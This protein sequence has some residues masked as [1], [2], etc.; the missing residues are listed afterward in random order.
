VAA[1]LALGSL[2]LG[3]IWI[4]AAP[5]E[6]S[7]SGRHRRA[8]VLSCPGTTA[9]RPGRLLQR[10]TD[11]DVYSISDP[12]RTTA[13]SSIFF[14][15]LPAEVFD[16]LMSDSEILTVPSGGLIFER[17]DRARSVFAVLSGMV[18]LSIETRDGTEA[19]VEVFHAGKSFAEA[20][21]FRRDV[22]PVSAIAL[23]HSRILSVPNEAV[24]RAIRAHPEAAGSILAATYSHLHSLVRQIEQ[25]KSNTGMERVGHFILSNVPPGNGSS[26]I[27]V[28]YEKQVLASLLGMKPETL[29]RAFR[30]LSAYGVSVDGKAI[31]LRDRRALERF[32][33]LDD[34]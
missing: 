28:P 33:E 27:Q 24:Q 31:I 25:L 13:R 6:S 21:A 3:H 9:R 26:S 30:K 14:G 10:R 20:L 18:K 19:I 4:C 7:N 1:I 2:K 32:L 11:V 15:S 8:L 17:G 23:T 34:P 22:Y 12:E 29:S 5:A 16:V